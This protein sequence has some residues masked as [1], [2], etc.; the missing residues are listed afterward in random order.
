MLAGSVGVC[1]LVEVLE[2]ALSEFSEAL[3]DN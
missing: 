3:L 1:I 2:I